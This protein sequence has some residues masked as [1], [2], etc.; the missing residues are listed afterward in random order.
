MSEDAHD[1]NTVEAL[2]HP[3]TIGGLTVP[4][5]V[6]MAPMTRNYSPGGVP[7][8]DVAAYYARRAAHGVGLIITEGTV[9]DHPA[10]AS[11]PRVPRLFGTA[12]L[13]GWADVVEAVHAAGGRIVSQLWHVGTD[14]TADSLPNPGVPPIGPSGLSLTG[15]PVAEPMT[16]A[17][18][19]QVIAA[20]ARAA[21][22][23]QRLGFDGIELHAGH[24][25]LIDQFFW[26]RTN[27]RTDR[28][29]GD[30]VARTRFAVD[31]VTACRRAVAP[32]FPIILRFSQ[33]KISDYAARLVETPAELAAFLTPLVAAG[34]DAFHCSTRR[35][36]LPAFA[37]SPLTLAGWTRK[38]SGRPTIAVG[39]VGLDGTEFLEFRH[40]DNAGIQAV[41]DLLERHEADLVA[42]GRTLLADPAWLEK[43]R[44]GRTAELIPYRPEAV[45]TLY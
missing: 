15:E 44:T 12:P 18:I 34:V 45:Q 21:A 13:A 22:D 40:A 23:A 42:A 43:I 8:P 10:S 25:Y 37:D 30:I 36:W 32:D 28:Y 16:E 9:I 2:F 38:L 33:W 11:N 39:S 14:R 29:G 24:G 5:R 17:E 3:F 41:V 6:L 35:F 7:G 26:E 20:F 31:I 19:E 27:R 1:P 4:N